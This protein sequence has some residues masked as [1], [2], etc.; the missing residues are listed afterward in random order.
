[1]G[2]IRRLIPASQTLSDGFLLDAA[3]TD[4][5]GGMSYGKCERDR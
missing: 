5:V 2:S 4:G 3:T 1:M